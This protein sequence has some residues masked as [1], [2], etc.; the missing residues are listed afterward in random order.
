MGWILG[1]IAAETILFGVRIMW[2]F[3]KM[4]LKRG[5]KGGHRYAKEIAKNPEL[6]KL[7]AGWR[8]RQT[9]VLA[10]LTSA[11]VAVAQRASMF[12]DRSTAVWKKLGGPSKMPGYSESAGV[13]RFYAVAETLGLIIGIDL[14]YEAIK[15][16]FSRD[17]RKQFLPLTLGVGN[18]DHLVED[19]ADLRVALH[20]STGG[21]DA[22]WLTDDEDDFVQRLLIAL[23]DPSSDDFSTVWK[24]LAAHPTWSKSLLMFST[25]FAGQQFIGAPSDKVTEAIEFLAS[26]S[27]RPVPEVRKAV[28]YA[29]ANL[30]LFA[31]DVIGVALDTV[32]AKTNDLLAEYNQLINIV[33][34]ARWVALRDLFEKLRTEPEE[35]RALDAASG[36]VDR[37]PPFLAQRER[38]IAQTYDV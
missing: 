17:E 13:R 22:R 2:G 26:E 29:V 38:Q 34:P 14:A 35:L 19:V 32:E 25:E 12:R 3:S 31:E 18:E 4:I 28:S 21:K 7:A 36:L 33:G 16:V 1:T 15:S 5:W 27:K 6:K 30:R 23:E 9:A 20:E 10:R 24:T 37:L 8:L 11:R